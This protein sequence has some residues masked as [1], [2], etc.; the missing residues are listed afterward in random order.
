MSASEEVA[1]AAEVAQLTER[2]FREEAGRL[3]ATLTRHFGVE[4]L[5]LAEDTVQEALARAL[6]LWPFYGVPE[7]PAAWLTRTAKNL[8]LDSVRRARNFAGKEAAVIAW[9]EQGS[10]GTASDPEENELRDDRLRLL[11]VCCH[12]HL[13][14]E[15]QVALALKT[16][17]GF[18]TLEISKAFLTT[19]ASMAKRLTRA[20]QR[21]RDDRIPFEIPSGP[22]LTERL[23]AVLGTLYLLFN[24]GYKASGGERLVRAELCFEAIRMMLLL[25]EHP[26]GDRPPAHALLALMLLNAARLETRS[27]EEGNLLRLEEQDRSRWDAELIARGLSHLSRSASGDELS[28]YHLQAGIAACHGAAPDYAATDW[29][30]ILALYDRLMAMD[31]SPIVALNRAIAVAKVRGPGAGLE[32]LQAIRKREMLESYHLLFAV[33]GDFQAEL[34]RKAE[35]AESFRQALALAHTESERAFL[36][37]RLRACPALM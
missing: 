17:G 5:Q 12:P 35:A 28:E 18:S 25:V 14:H 15:A 21:L 33:E 23:E 29:R 9:L 20:K 26:A 7:N 11:F 22:A 6:R 4:H 31:G 27:D 36:E 13:A 2:L 32:A 1:P 8:A 3:V 19:E 37:R 24:E 34:G 10:S 16:L 30:Q